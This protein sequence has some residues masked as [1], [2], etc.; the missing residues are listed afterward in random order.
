MSVRTMARVWADS[1]HG[2]SE[3]LMLLAIADFADDAG[4]AYPSV[5]GLAEKCRMKPRN[6]NYIL[7]D[8]QEGGELRV[9]LNRGPKGKN[10]YE[11]VFSAMSGGRTGRPLQAVAGSE[12]AEGVQ[13]IAGV[14]LQEGA[15]VHRVAGLQSSVG[16]PALQCSKPLHHSAAE[17]SL[18][19]QEPPRR[20]RE[21][22]PPSG[23]TFSEWFVS[24]KRDGQALFDP[25]DAVYAYQRKVGLPIEFVRLAWDAFKGAHEASDKRQADW[26]ATFRNYVKKGWLGLWYVD[27][28][29]GQYTLTTAGVQAAREYDRS[30]LAAAA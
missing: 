3:L 27:K 25:T 28:A 1:K 7:A 18:N 20:M 13:S 10:L 24:E 4:R 5:A 14:G 9:L 21:R 2:G 19:R 23:Q 6:A 22:T 8:L 17:P 12:A 15:G 30:E 16:T 29:S 26:K 11:I